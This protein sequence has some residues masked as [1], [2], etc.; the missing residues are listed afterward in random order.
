MM[1]TL[2]NA[3]N[4]FVVLL[5][6]QLS[7]LNNVLFCR[8][9]TLPERICRSL[10]PLF[11]TRNTFAF[12]ISTFLSVSPRAVCACALIQKKSSS[13]KRE[14]YCLFIGV[15]L[16]VPER[17]PLPRAKLGRQISPYRQILKH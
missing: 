16:P 7:Q 6:M 5:M 13:K 17:C 15:C 12:R 1:C 11:F 10:L 4:T 2:P 8:S 9:C 3:S 14:I